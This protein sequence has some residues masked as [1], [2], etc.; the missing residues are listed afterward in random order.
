VHRINCKNSHL[1]IMQRISKF[2]WNRRPDGEWRCY[3]S[4]ARITQHQ[5]QWRIIGGDYI[6]QQSHKTLAAAIAH[7]EQQALRA[8]RID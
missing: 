6:T 8:T 3:E 1:I 4:K 5:R 7:V 2:M